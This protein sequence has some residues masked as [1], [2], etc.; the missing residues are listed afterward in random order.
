MV[1]YPVPM[2]E[3]Y[4]IHTAVVKHLRAYAKPKTFFHH[5][6]NK[7]SSA[8]EGAR[9]KALGVVAGAP[10]LVLCRAG[11]YYGLELKAPGGVLSN[12]QIDCM[13][14]INNAGGEAVEAYGLADALDQLKRWGFL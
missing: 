12:A 9:A 5:P 14:R 4:A 10:D 6:F 2:H 1:N 7:A 11:Y 3:E 8:K 13:E